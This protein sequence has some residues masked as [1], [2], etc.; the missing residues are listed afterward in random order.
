MQ[1]Y[2]PRRACLVP[3]RL[4]LPAHTHMENVMH[5]CSC[6][7]PTNKETETLDYRHTSGIHRTSIL[8]LLTLQRGVTVPQVNGPLFKS[9]I[10]FL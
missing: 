4:D 10:S 6:E 1:L 9:V 8:V 3:L 5:R 2:K 7:N